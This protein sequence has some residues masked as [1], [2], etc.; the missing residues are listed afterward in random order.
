[1]ADKTTNR[2]SWWV[3]GILMSLL[4]MLT[5]STWGADRPIGAST[6]VPYITG[7]VLNLDPEHYTYLKEIKNAGSWEG[8]MLL[9]VFFGGF[10]TSVFITKTFRFSLVPT[11]WKKHKNKSVV[12]RLTWSFFAGFIMIIGAR[13]AG[14]CTSGHFLS[15]MSQ[16]A[17]SAMVFGAVVMLTLVITGKYF[18]HSK[19]I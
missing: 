3:S 15:G 5:I 10:I 12:S 1:L 18:Y 6:Y 17:M 7:L 2:L 9:G 8:I 14:G 4:L 19:E 16:M 11:G 13:L